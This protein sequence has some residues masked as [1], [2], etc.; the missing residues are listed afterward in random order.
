M[1]DDPDKPFYELSFEEKRE[2]VRCLREA[3]ARGE[4][5]LTPSEITFEANMWFE[6]EERERQ[7]DRRRLESKLKREKDDKSSNEWAMGCLAVYFLSGIL[8]IGGAALIDWLE[9]SANGDRLALL[10]IGTTVVLGFIVPRKWSNDVKEDYDR[11]IAA[12]SESNGY[13]QTPTTY[14]NYSEYLRSSHWKVTREKALDRAGLRCQLCGNQT[15]QLD[16]HHNNYRNLGNERPEDLI[17][18]CRT[19]HSRFHEGGRM[20]VR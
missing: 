19:C 1:A 20:P 3:E 12:L 9:I 5:G 10:W 18:L 11:R 14:S 4:G 7:E 13:G 15:G 6:V 16:V 2:R 8:G 17:V